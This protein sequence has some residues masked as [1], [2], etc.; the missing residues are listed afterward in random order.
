MLVKTL[1]V[2]N[3][4]NYQE[5]EIAFAPGR[6]IIIG[7]NAQGKTNL[8]EAIEYMA[9][10]K[11][12]RT[13]DD[14][15]LIKSGSDS[16]RIEINF[17]GNSLEQKIEVLVSKKLVGSPKGPKTML[18][19]KV[20]IN[21]VAY[22]RT[23]NLRGRLVVVSFK[24]LD[25]NLL[26]G[27]PKYRR[28]WLDDLSATLKPAYAKLSSRYTKTVTQR[29]RLLRQIF[30]NK[31]NNLSDR[32]ELKVWDQQVAS[33]G[34]SVVRSRLAVLKAII[35]LAEARQ[36][37]LSG[38]REKLTLDYFFHSLE[39]EQDSLERE[40]T[41]LHALSVFAHEESEDLISEK[42][43]EARLLDCLRARKEEEIVR[44]QT[45]T[46]PH[47]DDIRFKLNGFDAT[48]FASQG[49][50]R[51]LVLSLKLSEL[52][53]VAD[54]LKEPPILLLDDVLAE[55][56]LTRQ[57]YLMASVSDS[58]QTIITT[59]HVDGFEKE[60]LDGASFIEVK[61]GSAKAAPSPIF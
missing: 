58:M 14:K 31:R 2:K 56:D 48:A 15:E 4:R 30:E 11:S 38:T 51:S 29:N 52:F 13:A 23:S 32:D 43:I 59:T 6:T 33:L 8:L 20:K 49:Q 28:D 22:S 7:G 54:Y 12:G 40:D 57:G 26:R 10:G 53:L 25:L 44:R 5:E 35:P 36:E 34:A 19:K 3:F 46:G 1:R 45:L 39:K 41:S 37:H 42:E 17:I 24:S 21:G 9:F 16:T 18:E 55:L 27:G 50:Q 60:W 47:R 61:N